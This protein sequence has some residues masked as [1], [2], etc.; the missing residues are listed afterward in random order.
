M[1]T[2]RQGR[3]HVPRAPVPQCNRAPERGT[4][5]SCS[6]SNVSLMVLMPPPFYHPQERMH[7]SPP[8]ISTLCSL[9]WS[10]IFPSLPPQPTRSPRVPRV[11]HPGPSP[12][13]FSIHL[14]ICPNTPSPLSQTL[15][16]H[17]LSPTV[18]H[19]Q[20]LLCPQSLSEHSR[21][22]S[23]LKETWLCPDVI[24]SPADFPLIPMGL[25]WPVSTSLPTSAFQSLLFLLSSA[26]PD[27][28]KWA[29]PDCATSLVYSL[30]HSSK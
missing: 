2:E 21:H 30:S 9:N 12:P 25:E 1:C 19:Q 6:W 18:Y 17:P 28:S 16:P 20:M 22:F 11:I 15:P 8:N 24:T 4:P 5:A 7:A 13:N 10:P 23:A 26:G 3:I 27:P 14:L 29:P